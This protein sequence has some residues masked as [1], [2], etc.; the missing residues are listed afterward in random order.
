MNIANL[1]LPL[2]PPLV[3]AKI[4]G[5]FKVAPKPQWLKDR[6]SVYNDVKERR[7]KEVR[8][9]QGGGEGK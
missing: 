1:C 9:V 4:G 5:P 7:L 2:F 6:E 3:P 8:A